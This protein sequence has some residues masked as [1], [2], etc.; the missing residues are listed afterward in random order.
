MVI[1]YSKCDLVAKRVLWADLLATKITLGGGNWCILGDFNSVTCGDERSGV[2]PVVITSTEMREFVDFVEGM[3][4]V[5]LPVLGRRFTWFHSSG[6]AMSRIDRVF[7]SEDWLSI[8][9]H[10]SLW[11]LPRDVSDHCPLILRRN[12]HDWGPKPFRFNNAW[13]EH[14]DFSK[15]VEDEWG[16]QNVVGWMGFVLRET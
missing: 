13:L 9:G 10:S 14:K 6:S 5:D 15:V 2:N 7:V 11:V 4:L 3:D 8:W 12:G 1:V 16:R